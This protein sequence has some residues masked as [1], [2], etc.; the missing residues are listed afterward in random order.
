MSEASEADA[1][2]PY[3]GLPEWVGMFASGRGDLA[4]RHKEIIR[5]SAEREAR[6]TAVTMMTVVFKEP[7]SHEAAQSIKADIEE[8]HDV[9]YV[10]A[11]MG[12]IIS[13]ESHILRRVEQRM[14]EIMREDL[15][16]FALD[17]ASR[18]TEREKRSSN[19]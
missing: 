16:Q 6:E 19:E 17:Y 13:R 8:F 2:D 11:E 5:E 4:E 1:E 7:I 15:K 10:D 18:I 3:E 9:A 14:G 12:L